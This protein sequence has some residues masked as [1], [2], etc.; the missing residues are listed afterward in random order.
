[1]PP[2]TIYTRETDVSVLKVLFLACCLALPSAAQNNVT[3]PAESLLIGPGDLLNIQVFDTPELNQSPRVTDAGTAPI[4]L[5]G[6]IHLAGMTPA[7]AASAIEHGLM[8][9]RLMMKPLVTVGILEFATQSVAILGQVKMPGAYPITAPR[10]VIDMIATAGGLTDIADRR[11]TIERQS[12]P[13]KRVDFFLSNNSGDALSNNTLV[14]PGDK[15]IIPKAGLVY[16]LGDV[17]SP[18]GYVMN[19]NSSQLT[20][21]QAVAAAGGTNHSAVPSHSRLISRDGASGYKDKD[22]QLS[23]MQ[24]GKQPDIPLQPGDIVYVPFSYLRNL[25][26]QASGVVA[27]ATSASIYALP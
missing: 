21:L 14:Y 6:S 22:L 20:V 23:A 19:N 15:V 27:A 24:K 16:V 3:T 26:V 18:G 8:E 5:L 7:Q 9:K 2:P 17:K 4:L 11:I 13:S 25:A 1:M 12:D 10:S